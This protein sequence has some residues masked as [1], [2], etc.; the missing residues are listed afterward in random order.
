MKQNIALQAGKDYVTLKIL[1][2]LSR[3][4]VQNFDDEMRLGKEDL[5]YVMRI[6]G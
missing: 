4:A 1:T 3:E 6:N 5:L 2:Q